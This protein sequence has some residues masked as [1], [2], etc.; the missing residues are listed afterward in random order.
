MNKT[1][2]KTKKNFMAM[3]AIY[4]FGVFND[5]FFKQVIMILTIY[6]GFTQL[7]G[8]V[9]II[10]TAPY[11][12]IAAIAGWL[13]DKYSKRKVMVSAK[14]L[15]FIAMIFGA[16]GLFLFHPGHSLFSL[17]WILMLIMLGIMG[18]Q[19]SIFSP[20]L[21]ATIPEIFP[22]NWVTKANG[23]VKAVSTLGILFGIACA[24]FILDHKISIIGF[25]GILLPNVKKLLVDHYSLHQKLISVALLLLIF[26]FLGFFISFF[27]PKTKA[28]QTKERFP[29][30]GPFR[31]LKDIYGLRKDYLLNISVW[32]TTFFWF[33]G[34][35]Q[36]L[37]LNEMGL[38]Q[39]S[40]GEGQTS[41]LLVAQMLGVAIGAFIAGYF[42][43]GKTWYKVL[44]PA[45]WLITIF[46]F[47]MSLLPYFAE[48][49][50]YILALFFI[51]MAGVGG[52]LYI[53]PL[54]SYIQIHPKADQKGK[55]IAASNFLSFAF[56]SLSGIIYMVFVKLGFSPT[57][58]FM[59]VSI[60]SF[61]VL[62]TLFL[63]YS[64]HSLSHNLIYKEK[65][66]LNKIFLFIGKIVIKL[67]YK[68]EVKGL[69]AILKKGNQNIIFL[70][71]HTAF[72]DPIIIMMYLFPYFKQRHI[73]VENH[74]KNPIVNWLSSR[75][76]VRQIPDMGLKGKQAQS[77]IEEVLQMSKQ[78]LVDGQNV[79]IY[80]S[81]H[82]KR[83]INEKV[84]ANSGVKKL[85]EG[86][87]DKVRVVLVKQDGLWG[88]CLSW[89]M[90]KPH[91]PKGFFR[92]ILFNFFFF[93]PKRKVQ[94]QLVE[95]TD[96]PKQDTKIVQNKY[97]E[98][99]YNKDNW[100]NLYV[101]Y[102]IWA[103]ERRKVI[104]EP[105]QKTDKLDID[106]VPQQ[107]KEIVIN[108]LKDLT[109]IKEVKANDTLNYDLGLDSLIIADI[110][111]WLKEE[112]GYAV[113][114][115]DSYHRV[116]DVMLAAIGI[117]KQTHVEEISPPTNKWFKR[118]TY[119]Q[120]LVV[121]ETQSIL[122]EF[123]KKAK[124]NKKKI[125]MA[126]LVSGEKTYQDIILGIL[127]LKKVIQKIEGDKIGLM[128]PAGVGAN[129]F[130]FAAL[131]SEKI[132]VMINWTTGIKNIKECLKNVNVNKII[133]SKKLIDKL[134]DQGIDLASIKEM[135]IFVEDFKK[136]ISIISK[137]KG[138]ILSKFSWRSLKKVKPK[139]TAV[140]LFTSG[141]ENVPKAVPLTH[142]NILTNIKDLTQVINVNP[143][144][145]IIGF[146]PPFH[147]FGLVVTH[148]LPLVI[149]LPVVFYA[150]PTQA[151]VVA[152]IIHK[153]KVS[154]LVS[155]PTFLNGII[156]NASQKYLKSLRIVVSGAE[157]CSDRIYEEAQKLCPQANILEAYGITE[158]SP[159]VSLNDENYP[160]KQSIGKVLPSIHYKIIHHETYQQVES[161]KEGM[162]IVK[163]PSI[164]KG[165]EQYS[166]PSPFIEIE[167]EN[168][169]K[170]GDIVYEK[171]G[172]LFF[173]AR[174]KRFIKLGGEMISLPAIEE[175]LS[176]YFGTE[177]EDGQILAIEATSHI[178][179]PELVLFTTLKSLNR[180]QVNSVIRDAGLSAL[181]N[182]K[183]VIQ[184]DE[185]PLLGT[186]KTDYRAL[187]KMI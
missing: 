131:F 10:F 101:A 85:L 14:F 124:S 4:F 1:P 35:L 160:V 133:T 45:L 130:Y 100:P 84:G 129:I 135:F 36:I 94:I 178:E 136:Q 144:D 26:A 18:L 17:S 37:I 44:I 29:W 107:T 153:Y 95:P 55:V 3:L 164:F 175:V 20:S 69:E 65:S 139:E 16:I 21:N 99:F 155:T 170:T 157:K 50:R 140:V 109:G 93:F 168:W 41:L 173:K 156:R 114:D 28:A 56:L 61:L 96:F 154:L 70:P 77:K 118:S 88:S 79:L 30:A 185:I 117:G 103:K 180:S 163:G 166:G 162:L 71:N 149:A 75:L 13:A 179:N 123:L 148:I 102:S 116:A 66:L 27:T 78:N 83:E 128:F 122:K 171:D 110:I 97:L 87:E 34:M 19:S 23:R 186:G 115:T 49:L 183:K 143:Q 68:V 12:V 176:N 132:P 159:A 121:N 138:L 24:G 25:E 15:E 146:I 22:H 141:S 151:D 82:L 11:L 104:P 59:V 54:E 63:L 152:S 51:C 9:A 108:Y 165:Y 90:G 150:N 64:K 6:I 126:D 158:C 43:K 187:K 106:E 105:S 142:K 32:A 74:L 181:H 76:G 2:Q 91:L 172:N 5:N 169:Y 48:P 40:W 113:G 73:G 145:S 60:F 137:I 112:F 46:F 7:Q 167:G 33:L 111:N 58:D 127:V 125:I 98:N 184:I 147:S 119:Q 57:K 72:I 8:M 81:G 42:S 62:L 92:N 120:R 53:I 89:G 80:P 161:D 177:D 47:L 134:K 182:I 67:R 31:S 174:L 52:G 38:K 39:F 86:I